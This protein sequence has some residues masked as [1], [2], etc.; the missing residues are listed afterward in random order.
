MRRPI[1][2]MFLP[3][4]F[5]LQLGFFR[6]VTLA[7]QS[8]LITVAT[9][10][11]ALFLGGCSAPSAQAPAN[12]P[13]AAVSLTENFRPALP[14][15]PDHAVSLAEFGAV[16][17]GQTLNTEAFKRAIKAIADAGGGKL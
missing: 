15:I 3:A 4:S 8:F 16:G 9:A 13:A 6:S 14:V 5:S 17:D 1:R 12:A 2:H 11:A 10:G 7:R